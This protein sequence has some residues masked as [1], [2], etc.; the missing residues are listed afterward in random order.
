MNYENIV[1]NNK[2]LKFLIYANPRTAFF[3]DTITIVKSFSANA[4][5]GSPPVGQTERASQA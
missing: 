2:H 3:N 5:A 1:F 4:T